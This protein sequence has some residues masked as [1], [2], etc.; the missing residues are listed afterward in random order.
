MEHLVT[1]E[2]QS[3]SAGAPLPVRAVVA[4]NRSPVLAAPIGHPGRVS[5][6]DI[7]SDSLAGLNA[8]GAGLHECANW[9]GRPPCSA[10]FVEKLA[11]IR[12]E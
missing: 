12:M 3:E 11:K 2:I 6:S 10:I 8:P 7:V 9:Q 5:E 4:A 1:T